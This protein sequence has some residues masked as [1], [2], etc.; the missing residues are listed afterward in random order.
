MT[1]FHKNLHNEWHFLSIAEQMANIGAEVGRSIKWKKKGNA[2][3]STNAFYRALE[4]IDFTIAD[5]HNAKRLSELLRVREFYS[6]FLIGDN[7]YEF[8]DE[9][10]EKYFLYFNLCVASRKNR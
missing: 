2:E 9:S 4:L 6:D 8:T 5:P 3:T 7:Q 10:W 1:T